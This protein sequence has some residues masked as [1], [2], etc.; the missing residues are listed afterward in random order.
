[1]SGTWSIKGVLRF[2][3][4]MAVLT[5]AARTVPAYGQAETLL[6][7]EIHNG[8]YGA[9]VLKVT[10]ING[11]AG[12][13]IGGRGGWIINHCFVIG[14]GG[15]GLATGIDAPEFSSPADIASRDLD[16]EF[17]Y[18]GLELEY[19]FRPSKLVH[20]TIGFMLGGGGIGYYEE[21]DDG[22]TESLIDDEVL[23]IEP[24]V[25]AELNVVNWM[26]IDGGVSYR[27]VSGL[28]M[29]GLDNG[30]MSGLAGFLI[31]KFGSF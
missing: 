6:G 10:T 21:N 29:P 13:L 22:D 14:G 15:Y 24:A 28:D 31:F 23:V 9:P 12:V 8:G 1:M 20:G 7:G 17:G 11:A 2:G 18:G 26:R 30:D 27:A 5:L 4:L 3:I 19:I 16:I 25:A